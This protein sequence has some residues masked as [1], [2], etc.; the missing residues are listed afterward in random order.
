[1]VA[2]VVVVVVVGAAAASA[3]V[4]WAAAVWVQRLLHLQHRQ[5]LPQLRQLL[6][7]L[8]LAR[9]AAAKVANP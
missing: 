1:V 2:A 8:Q 7:Q 5:R 6:L 3:A 9:A 4:V